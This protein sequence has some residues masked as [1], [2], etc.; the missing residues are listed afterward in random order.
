MHEIKTTKTRNE[1]PPYTEAE[2]ETIHQ[3]TADA[4]AD[5]RDAPMTVVRPEDI[6]KAS[7][8]GDCPTCGRND[9]YLN[10]GAP[11]G[12]AATRTG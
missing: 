5:T 8:F 11:T 12:C 7:Y 9:G 3:A 6:P 4:W 10:V 1:L 2:L